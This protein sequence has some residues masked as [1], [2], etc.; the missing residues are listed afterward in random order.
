MQ[1][2]NT[3]KGI[4]PF[5]L[6][7]TW[8]PEAGIHTIILR[9]F[10]G[11]GESFQRTMYTTALALEDLDADGIANDVDTCPDQPGSEAANG[12]PD[13]DFD[14]ITDATDTCPDEAGLPPNG[15]PAPSESDRDGD[16]MLDSADICPDEVGSPLADGC[17]DTDGDGTADGADSCPAEPG[18]GADGCPESSDSLP[19]DP[20]PG[21]EEPPP[22]P[23]P[24]DE[25]PLPEEG[26]GPESPG[27]LGEVFPFPETKELIRLKIEAYYLALRN[28]YD[29]LRC[30]LRFDDQDP[31]PYD[32]ENFDDLHWDIGA[33]LG[34]ENNLVIEHEET[35]PLA[36]LLDCEGSISD[37][38]PV[39][40]VDM[41]ASH[42]R[43]EW[44]GRDLKIE[45]ADAIVHYRIIELSCAES[46][47]PAPTLNPL[48]FGAWGEG[49]FTLSWR[50]RGDTRDISGFRLVI[51]TDDD[52]TSVNIP[53][54]EMRSL[55]VEDYMP[56]CGEIASFQI[57]A[58]Q[59]DGDLRSAMSNT[60]EWP[61]DACTYTASVTFTTLEVHNPPADEEGLHRPG[62]IY[63]NF[64]VSNGTTIE[65]LD[66]NACWCYFG[67]GSTF[68]GW[69]EGLELPSGTYSINRGIF[70]WIDTAQ[71][72]C[73]GDGCNSNDFYAP[74]S[75]SLHIPLENDSDLTIGG[76]IMDCDAKNSD[77]VVFEEQGGIRIN[78][79]ELEYFTVPIP[80]GLEGNHINLNTFIR[81]GR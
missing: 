9:A 14:G 64:W 4:N 46:I 45:T 19:P 72:S 47:C 51:S 26:E 61:G 58:Y 31:I 57:Y 67:P 3:P 39:S 43:A 21:G 36:I 11:R 56:A 16:G 52:S 30:Y 32:I 5:P 17:P 18:S 29:R 12:C 79:D 70:E 81:M 55:N 80:F 20:L 2:S 34:S 10:N 54:P 8:Y 48:T 49:P 44:D 7:T 40:L 74:F 53:N 25:P 65:S 68:W 77:D 37:G 76:R 69:C 22:L 60:Q 6:L 41:T 23:R 78:V 73:I 1:E 38:R 33:E 13:R 24:G 42:P 27:G 35:D 28:P 75:S 15:C 71:A 59:A 50:W 63:G 62:P 66:F